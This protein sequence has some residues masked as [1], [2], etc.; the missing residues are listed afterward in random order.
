MDAGSDLRSSPKAMY[1][2]VTIDELQTI[3]GSVSICITT[4][5]QAAS[6]LCIHLNGTLSNDS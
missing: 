6:G 5:V 4:D 1:N 2:N 3:A